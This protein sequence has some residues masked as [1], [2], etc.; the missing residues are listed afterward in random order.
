[1]GHRKWTGLAADHDAMIRATLH[2]YRGR[3]VKT[4]GDGF[5]ATFDAST[6]AVRAAQ[7][8]VRGRMG[9]GSLFGRVSILARSK[10]ALTMSS[11]CL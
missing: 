10:S 6:R 9:S 2:R 5:L 7:E 8:V 4:T 11:V 1:M 3:E